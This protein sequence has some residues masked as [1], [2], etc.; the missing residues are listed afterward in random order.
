VYFYGTLPSSF[1]LHLPHGK[2]VLSWMDTKTG[3][4]K[5]REVIT[6]SNGKV[7]VSPPVYT[8]DIAL[9]IMREK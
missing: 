3:E 2:Y 7:T 5:N 8:G 6:S 4:Y 9:K 1:E